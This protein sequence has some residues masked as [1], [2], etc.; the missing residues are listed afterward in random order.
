MQLKSIVQLLTMCR[1]VK[2]KESEE[3]LLRKDSNDLIV[4]NYIDSIQGFQA[5]K[6]E[7]DRNNVETNFVS[8][9]GRNVMFSKIAQ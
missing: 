8:K 1:E 4:Q 5:K 7:K 2:E 6:R 9:N 3:I